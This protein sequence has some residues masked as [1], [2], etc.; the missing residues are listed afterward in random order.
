MLGGVFAI[1]G[2][3]AV[4]PTVLSLVIIEEQIMAHLVPFSLAVGTVALALGALWLQPL[5]MALRSW[6]FLRRP[7][8]RRPDYL[9]TVALIAPCRG[10][11]QGFETNVRAVLAQDYPG[12]QVIFVTGSTE[13]PAYPI[14]ARIVPEYPHARLLVA[15]QARDRGQKVHNLLAG[16]AAAG[17]VDVLAFVDSD[18]RPHQGWLRSLVAPL[19]DPRVG[20]STG[21]YW[22]RPERGGLWSWARA[23]AA[24]LTALNMAHE[25]NT[26]LWGGAMAV[27]MEVFERAGVAGAWQHALADDIVIAR[28]IERLGLRMTLVPECFT[29]I[30]EDTDFAG[31]WGFVFRHLV[32]V[33]A[34]DTRTWMIVGTVLALPVLGALGGGSL[35]LTGLFFREALLLAALLLLQFPLQVA[36]GVAVP[37]VVFRDRRLALAA[38]L[39]LLV[40][41][42]V[43]GAYL[44]SALTRKM[45]W[46]GITYEVLSAS[47]T[48]VLP[49]GESSQPWERPEIER[50]AARM[51]EIPLNARQLALAAIGRRP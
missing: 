18:A 29:V 51:R 27:R 24:N 3:V 41:P 12:Y 11:D 33:R 17:P 25:G 20:G 43:L 1:V 38:P 36:Y 48:R 35:L 49:P 21:H 28:Q 9:P 16:V 37:A 15:G 2:L 44:A 13:D 47:E 14:L 19:A 26:G 4:E 46:R 10:I 45:T 7:R 50:A 5:T 30:A 31:F 8:S 23:L 42:V 39:L 34:A 6:H 22:Y 40:E 32:I